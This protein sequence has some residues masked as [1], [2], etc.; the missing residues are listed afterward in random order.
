MTRLLLLGFVLVV[1]MLVIWVLW[2]EAL[3]ARAR[4]ARMA[5]DAGLEED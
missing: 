2:G 4:R 5:D 3:V 1:L